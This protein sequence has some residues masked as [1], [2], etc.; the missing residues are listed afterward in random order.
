MP[1]ANGAQGCLAIAGL[2]GSV[3]TEDCK[4]V[5]FAA[6]EIGTVEQRPI[7]TADFPPTRTFPVEKR[8]ARVLLIGGVHGDEY[9]AVS[10]QF[11]WA[12]LS[13]IHIS[14][15]TRPY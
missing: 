11:R 6:A 8:P 13:L 9:S 4:L 2:L 3:S 12:E 15:P 14:E 10:I 7:L 5:E 1:L